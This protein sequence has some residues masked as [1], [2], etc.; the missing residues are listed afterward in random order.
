MKT[1]YYYPG[2]ALYEKA[3]NFDQSTIKSFEILGI[4]L[5]EIPCW[6]CCGVV[7]P[8]A[9]ENLMGLVA[10][11]RNLVNAAKHG[12]EFTTGCSC[13]YNTLKR[14]NNTLRNDAEK[15]KRINA[16]LESDTENHYSGQVD[17]LHLL[18][19]LRDKIGFN[20]V[21]DRVRKDLSGLKLAGFYGCKLVR[22]YDE[23]GIDKPERPRILDDFI[24]G[25]GAQ[26]IDY[27]YKII[28]CGKSLSVV[29]EFS[30]IPILSSQK[31]ILSV[32]ESGAEAIVTSCPLCFYNLEQCQKDFPVKEQI[33]IF[34]F[35]QI[36][37]IALGIDY[38][39]LGFKQHLIN[40]CVLLKSKDLV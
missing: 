14:A 2:C 34:Y 20:K 26:A 33:P 19:V 25:L 16:F 23:M 15:Q 24:E 3:K 18:E 7:F 35:T 32:R 4:E 5:K 37:G 13:C 31:I 9:D 36:L 38:K 12:N 1:L 30:E 27:P 8:L 40:P 29:E 11:A 17:V 39:L 10:P 28:C 21:A 22:P 6:T